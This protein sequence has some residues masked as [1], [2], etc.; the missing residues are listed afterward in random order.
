VTITI[1][2]IEIGT[3]TEIGIMVQVATAIAADTVMNL[4][5][6]STN[7]QDPL[8]LQEIPTVGE[9]ETG[10]ATGMEEIVGIEMVTGMGEI[11]TEIEIELEMVEGIEIENGKGIPPLLTKAKGEGLK[12][13]SLK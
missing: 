13:V 3:E 7:D 12:I 5:Q 1:E 8:L 11:G 9:I 6:G 4:L 10:K 2:K